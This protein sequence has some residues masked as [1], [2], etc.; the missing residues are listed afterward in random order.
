[1]ATSLDAVA[2]AA[3]PARDGTA[4]A[5]R[6]H[7][8]QLALE[9]GGSG[10]AALLRRWAR[11]GRP[12]RGQVF[13]SAE[14]EAAITAANVLP[15]DAKE[16]PADARE[17]SSHAKETKDARQPTAHAKETK[18][19]QGARQIAVKAADNRRPDAGNS[20]SG[21]PAAQGNGGSTRSN[22][23]ARSHS[24]SSCSAGGNSQAGSDS[25]AKAGK[26]RTVSLSTK[27]W[28]TEAALQG[29][30]SVAS[31]LG[32]IRPELVKGSARVALLKALY[33]P[34]P[35]GNLR[36]GHAK[37]ADV[38]VA[39]DSPDR[40]VGAHRAILGAVSE[41]C[42]CKFDGN[43]GD[44]LDNTVHATNFSYN[45]VH[46]AIEFAYVG[47]CQIQLSDLGATVALADYLQFSEL[48]TAAEKCWMSLPIVCCL[49]V[50]AG[51]KPDAKVP[52][53]MVDALVRSLGESFSRVA[54]LLTGQDSAPDKVA[55][56]WQF[57]QEL[58]NWLVQLPEDSMDRFRFWVSMEND[59][60]HD[61]T[62][63]LILAVVRKASDAANSST[64]H[65]DEMR[66]ICKRQFKAFLPE[67]MLGRILSK[68]MK[69]WPV[70]RLDWL[71]SGGPSLRV[72]F[73]FYNRLRSHV[74]AHDEEA[75]AQVERGE[76]PPEAIL[77]QI[78]TADFQKGFGLAFVEEAYNDSLGSCFWETLLRRGLLEDRLPAVEHALQVFAQNVL[79]GRN[80]PSGLPVSVVLHVLL[81]ALVVAPALA[82]QVS[83]PEALAGIYQRKGERNIYVR[84][85]SGPGLVLRRVARATR[86]EEE[87]DAIHIVWQGIPAEVSRQARAEW[88]VQKAE[89]DENFDAPLAVAL[90]ASEDPCKLGVPWWIR[91]PSGKFKENASMEI[92][93]ESIRA[94]EAAACKA[95]LA[96]WSRSGGS[97]A[98]LEQEAQNR[99]SDEVA[100][101]KLCREASALLAKMTVPSA[102]DAVTTGTEA[103][104]TAPAEESAVPEKEESR[105]EK[106]ENDPEWQMAVQAYDAAVDELCNVFRE[107]SRASS[108]EEKRRLLEKKRR[109]EEAPTFL[110]AV[111]RLERARPA[112]PC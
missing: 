103:P 16:T 97:L 11:E 75:R 43:Y 37:H 38:Q 76:L 36:E 54:Q 12:Y 62:E 93:L 111:R 91:T 8:L 90:S 81:E 63:N 48:A 57:V 51:L 4:P 58:H 14:V 52:R 2:Q 77:L 21:A 110:A 42:R 94:E 50:L 13:S 22:I 46:A 95:V 99:Y 33:D 65:C 30:V 84:Q 15:S 25:V 89:D 66:L 88:K 29:A 104:K 7:L 80:L 3:T 20:S 92:R 83:G 85:G 35:E 39:T 96:S 40:S 55:A 71:H 82:V 45:V 60:L 102:D 101:P 108:A 109:L 10:C 79:R 32:P 53:A 78:Q 9:K 67:A 24:G 31:S 100:L 61:A 27:N 73:D 28:P 69:D 74:Q 26:E 6:K 72:M 105:P 56:C 70:Y 34:G 112:E 98:E 86:R 68:L 41:L 23:D 107:V 44:A 106:E 49:G 19:G 5:L 64:I 17:P 59:E 47:R 87:R 1:M 18:G